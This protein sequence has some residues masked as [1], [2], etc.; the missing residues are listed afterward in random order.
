MSQEDKRAKK[1]KKQDAKRL[2]KRGVKLLDVCEA[3]ETADWVYDK[4]ERE[5]KEKWEKM[6]ADGVKNE[7][8]KLLHPEE[9]KRSA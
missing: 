5:R 9:K 4:Q 2:A 6:L 7:V 3:V 1:R 8:Y